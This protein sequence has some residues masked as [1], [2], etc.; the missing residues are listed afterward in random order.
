[1]VFSDVGSDMAVVEVMGMADHAGVLEVWKG[2][3]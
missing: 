1:M 3:D 2:S